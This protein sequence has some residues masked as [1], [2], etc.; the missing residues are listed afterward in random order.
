MYVFSPSTP[1]TFTA[2]VALIL[3][4]FLWQKVI[5]KLENHILVVRGLLMILS[6]ICDKVFFS[7]KVSGFW[8]A[9]KFQRKTSI[10]DVCQDSDT[11]CVNS[12]LATPDSLTL[13]LR[14]IYISNWAYK[15]M[16]GSFVLR[17]TFNKFTKQKNTKEMDILSL[18]VSMCV[19]ECKK[20]R[21]L[22]W[23]KIYRI[24]PFALFLQ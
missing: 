5:H 23:D 17:A 16:W 20:L 3:L 12:L 18:C 10:V 7:K 21:N 6:K 24:L 11:L 1:F 15:C 13:F 9:N 22:W 2:L 14:S 4:E 19:N 8:A